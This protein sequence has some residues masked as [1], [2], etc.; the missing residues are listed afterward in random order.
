MPD[1]CPKSLQDGRKIL[2][3]L[4][5]AGFYR[6]K[7]ALLNEKNMATKVIYFTVSG[8]NDQAEF[9]CDDSPDDVKGEC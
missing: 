9:R 1:R 8:R 6:I 7:L 3:S 5:N 2:H 4:E